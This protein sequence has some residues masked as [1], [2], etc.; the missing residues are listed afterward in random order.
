MNSNINIHININKN[1]NINFNINI[2]IQKIQK[3]VI[4]V[5]TFKISF[6]LQQLKKTKI[7]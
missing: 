2:N 7:E 4:R 3:V 5:R 1:T 6:K